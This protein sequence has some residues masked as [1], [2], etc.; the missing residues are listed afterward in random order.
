M[1]FGTWTVERLYR[2]GLLMTVVKDVSEHKLDLV[3][4][5]EVR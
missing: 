2:A 3:T 4:A 1:K 5:Q